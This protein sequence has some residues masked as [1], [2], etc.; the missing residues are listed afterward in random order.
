MNTNFVIA[1]II[2]IIKGKFLECRLVSHDINTLRNNCILR[3]NGYRKKHQVSSLT[4]NSA[5]ENIA[6]KYSEKLAASGEFYPS[7]NTF[8]GNP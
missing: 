4:I 8:K 2:L 7:D 6:H 3:H 5:I 1:L